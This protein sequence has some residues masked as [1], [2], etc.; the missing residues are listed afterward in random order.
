ML[1]MT[2]YVLRIISVHKTLHFMYFLQKRD[3]HTDGRTDGPT[4]TPSYRDARTHLK[5]S[6]AHSLISRSIGKECVKIT[7]RF[8]NNAFNFLSFARLTSVHPEGVD[9]DL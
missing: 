4:D 1:F 7:L 6:F 8:N 2:L 9:L 3:I 5:R